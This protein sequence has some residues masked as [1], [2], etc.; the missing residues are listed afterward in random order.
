MNVIAYSPF[1]D[2]G[3]ADATGA[4]QS[5]IAAGAAHNPTTVLKL[6][7]LVWATAEY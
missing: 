2:G 1:H 5:A 7:R 4:S 6:R 3:S